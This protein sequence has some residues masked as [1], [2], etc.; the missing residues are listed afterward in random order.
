MAPHHRCD[1][2]EARIRGSAHR[3]DQA[4]DTRGFVGVRRGHA[5]AAASL[6]LNRLRRAV[7]ALELF[8]LRFIVWPESTRA[9]M[10]ATVAAVLH[11]F[12]HQHL[13]RSIRVT[14]LVEAID[15]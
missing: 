11:R 5:I 10:A 3:V 8:A 2:A 1:T 14:G 12:V 4:L 9:V 7:D 15:C 13:P 6:I